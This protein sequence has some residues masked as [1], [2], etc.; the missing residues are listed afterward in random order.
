MALMHVRLYWSQEVAVPCNHSVLGAFV[1]LEHNRVPH[2]R[3]QLHMYVFTLE[4]ATMV[5]CM[6]GHAP[7]NICSTHHH[8]RAADLGGH[9]ATTIGD[10]ASLRV[11]MQHRPHVQ[12]GLLCTPIAR[13]MMVGLAWPRDVRDGA[14]CARDIFI[15]SSYQGHACLSI[16]I[17]SRH[18]QTAAGSWQANHM[19]LCCNVWRCSER[20]CCDQGPNLLDFA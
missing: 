7:S 13:E 14:S 3:V 19:V 17:Q 15:P 2:T 9:A 16:C 4:L 11:S 5:I 8:V 10:F 12:L 6:N 1:V 18:E 20:A